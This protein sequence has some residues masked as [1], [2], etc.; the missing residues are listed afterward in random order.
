MA[1]YTHTHT[2]TPAE[3][4]GVNADSQPTRQPPAIKRCSRRAQGPQES[5]DTRL[6]LPQPAR[7]IQTCTV[8]QVQY[9]H[10]IL[11]HTNTRPKALPQT[12][13]HQ[14]GR[15]IVRWQK[16]LGGDVRWDLEGDWI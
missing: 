14:M 1:S 9:C 15:F 13:A 5:N 2:H 16:V 10:C 8:C 4:S 11:K 12:L 3:I 7:L 6:H